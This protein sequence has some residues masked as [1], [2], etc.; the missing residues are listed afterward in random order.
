MTMRSSAISTGFRALLMALLVACATDPESDRLVYR[1]TDENRL[2]L[3]RARLEVSSSYTGTRQFIADQ[4]GRIVLEHGASDWSIEVRSVDRCPFEIRSSER[5]ENDAKLW[6]VSPSDLRAR[7]R[8][9]IPFGI[10]GAPGQLVGW[11]QA[12]H[13]EEVRTGAYWTTTVS[14]TTT[15]DAQGRGTLR[16][17]S[18]LGPFREHA[19]FRILVRGVPF[20]LGAW[21]ID[22]TDSVFTILPIRV[23]IAMSPSTALARGLVTDRDSLW[24]KWTYSES[25]VALGKRGD[26]SARRA[27]FKISDSV[28]AGV[29]RDAPADSFRWVFRY[30]GYSDEGVLLDTGAGNERGIWLRRLP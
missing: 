4:F 20:K 8:E 25:Y 21:W 24:M 1:I 22:P 28:L 2:P 6:L 13:R 30:L 15:L 18:L 17:S 27:D 3:S 10:R 16:I 7:C 26:T 29:W 9:T 11:S 14:D 5:G 19:N 12:L 23:G